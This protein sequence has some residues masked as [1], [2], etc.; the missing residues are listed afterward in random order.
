MRRD[1]EVEHLQT[2]KKMIQD[3]CQSVGPVVDEKRNPL[4]DEEGQ[5][6]WGSKKE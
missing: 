4:T 2:S 5:T 1:V 6:R 3:G